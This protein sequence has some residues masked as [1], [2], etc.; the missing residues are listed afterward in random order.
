[1]AKGWRPRLPW[2]RMIEWEVTVHP[3]GALMTLDAARASAALWE[4]SAPLDAEAGSRL[5][6]YMTVRA[7]LPFLESLME[8]FLAEWLMAE[9]WRLKK[10]A[11][12]PPVE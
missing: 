7:P 12:Q 9:L 10:V 6:L 2:L 1:L 8:P 3:V 4:V 5:R 11:E